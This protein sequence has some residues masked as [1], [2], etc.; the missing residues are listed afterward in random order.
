MRLEAY[1]AYQLKGVKDNHN[2]GEDSGDTQTDPDCGKST[3]QQKEDQ[4]QRENHCYL[5]AE[6]PHF[7]VAA[8]Y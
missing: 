7:T 6:E 1:E 3:A 8:H 2:A 4:E 5:K